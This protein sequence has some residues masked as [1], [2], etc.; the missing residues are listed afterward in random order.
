ML[1]CQTIHE[2]TSVPI[3]L[4]NLFVWLLF[5]LVAAAAASVMPAHVIQ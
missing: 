4:I 5:F 1:R 2:C 3:V